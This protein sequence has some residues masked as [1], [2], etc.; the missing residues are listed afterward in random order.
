MGHSAKS[1]SPDDELAELVIDHLADW[2]RVTARRMFGGVGLFR[3]KQMFGL[4]YDGVVYFKCD[5]AQSPFFDAV[6][7][8]R[9]SYRRGERTITMSYR[10]VPDE[11]L[12]DPSLLQEWA[13][14]GWHAARSQK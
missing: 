1:V 5:A 7:A 13:A 2:A 3:D 11:A 10:Q 8:P 6:G 4:V 9:F 14:R 12:D